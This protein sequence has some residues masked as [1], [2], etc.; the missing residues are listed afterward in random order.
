MKIPNSNRKKALIIVDVQSAF[1]NRRNK[2]TVNNICKFISSTNYDL[3]VNAIFH[4]EKGSI[5]D[6]QTDWILPKDK[7]F[8]TVEEIDSLLKTKKVIHIEK[9][10]KS[11][12][13]GNLDLKKILKDYEIQ[14][15]HIVGFD[16]DDCILA[17]AYESFDYGFFTYVIEECC[18]S[19]NI[20]DHK[21]ALGTLN[22]MNLTNNSCI[23]KL[24][25]IK[26]K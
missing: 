5:W 13:K 18:G 7:D 10:T 3:Y 24:D 2:Y 17:T 1:I 16:T 9:T 23:G 20:R 12:F 8:H 22:R 14:E 15:V 11:V 19:E 26:L 4:A 6:K 25:F 21:R